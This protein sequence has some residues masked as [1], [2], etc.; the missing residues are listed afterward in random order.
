VENKPLG[1]PVQRF[2]GVPADWH[3]HLVGH[4]HQQRGF[5]VTSGSG[6]NNQFVV[7]EVE[8]KI[9]EALA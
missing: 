4:V 3:L 6:N 1:I 7:Q 9:K 8:E 2:Q 5:A